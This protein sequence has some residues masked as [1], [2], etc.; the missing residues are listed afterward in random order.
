MSHSVVGACGPQI[1]DHRTAGV[2]SLYAPSANPVTEQT[3]NLIKIFAA[4]AQSL[5]LEHQAIDELARTRDQLQQ[6]LVSRAVIDQAKGMI[7]MVRGCDANQAFDY[8][9]TLSNA[10]N[11]K[12]REVATGLIA[13]DPR[14]LEA[15]LPQGARAVCFD[16]AADRACQLGNPD[17]SA[18]HDPAEVKLTDA[19]GDTAWS[20]L[21]H[22]EE[23]L[24]AARGVFLATKDLDGVAA[25]LTRRWRA[26]RSLPPNPP[27]R[28]RTDAS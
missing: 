9:V 11:E 3:I 17:G 18:C 20:C 14:D 8:L 27:I 28:R 23:A 12:L 5:L 24:L 10:R 21:N 19:W 26:G 22:A 2:L 6:A 13:A 4:K 7:M 25:Y 16:V 1:V 15:T